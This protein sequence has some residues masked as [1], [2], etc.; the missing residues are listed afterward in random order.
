MM[1]RHSRRLGW[2]GGGGLVPCM[3]FLCR[4]LRCREIRGSWHRRI[5]R[6]LGIRLMTRKRY[7]RMNNVGGRR[8]VFEFQAFF[9]L[10][11]RS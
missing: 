2:V 10:V 9:C 6:C 1:V 5:W 7:L 4:V 3:V 11:N 8:L